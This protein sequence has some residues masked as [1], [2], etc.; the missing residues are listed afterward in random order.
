VDGR[1]GPLDVHDCTTPLPLL[2]CL[3]GFTLGLLIFPVARSPA[4]RR[5]A[6]RPG[7]S[8]PVLAAIVVLLMLPG[9]DLLAV[10]LF[11]ML[12]LTLSMDRG[13]FARLMGS[14]VLHVLGLL[15]YSLYL[16]HFRFIWGERVLRDRLPANWSDDMRQLI[17]F[18]VV[19]ALLLGCSGL[20]YL[21]VE[22]PCRALLRSP[23]IPGLFRRWK[24]TP[25][26]VD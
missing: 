18:V 14:P 11:P 4:V 21:W 3:A 2:R 8:A 17:A 25:Q 13:R 20:T 7:A 19:F 24:G 9:T 10:L 22:K 26:T 16:L 15:S 1:V 23:R 12:V 6:A 5:W